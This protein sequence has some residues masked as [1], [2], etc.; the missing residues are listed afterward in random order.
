MFGTVAAEHALAR[1][2]AG[3]RGASQSRLVYSLTDTPAYQKPTATD[4]PDRPVS[5]TAGNSLTMPVHAHD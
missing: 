4:G 2:Y 1:R 5:L 3:K